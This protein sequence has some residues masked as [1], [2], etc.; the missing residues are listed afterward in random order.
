MV[1]WEGMYEGKDINIVLDGKSLSGFIL[2]DF[3]LEESINE[4]QK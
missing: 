2:K 3:V 1:N 4:H